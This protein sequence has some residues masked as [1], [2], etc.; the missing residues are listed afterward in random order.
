MRTVHDCTAL[1]FLADVFHICAVLCDQVNPAVTLS[2]LATRRL[3]VL[4]ALV[5]IA[6]QCLGASLGAGALYLA[7]PLKT[8]AD[9]FINR[10]SSRDIIVKFDKRNYIFLFYALFLPP[11]SPSFRCP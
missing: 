4:R 2:L 8:T 10:V 1:S 7:L 9:H 5:Y 11:S 3:D 6:A